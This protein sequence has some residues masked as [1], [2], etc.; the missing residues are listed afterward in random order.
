MFPKCDYE[1][2]KKDNLSIQAF[3]KRLYADQTVYEYLLEF[4][5]VYSSDKEKTEGKKLHIKVHF[6]FI[7]I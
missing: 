4:L 3:G 2:I 1:E 5:L 7:K 6:N